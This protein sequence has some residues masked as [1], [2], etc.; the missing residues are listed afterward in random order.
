M[1]Q[2]RIRDPVP[3]LPLDPGS[4]M[5]K[6]SNVDSVRLNPNVDPDSEKILITVTVRVS[7]EACF[8]IILL[9]ICR[10]YYLLSGI[11]DHYRCCFAG[12]V[13]F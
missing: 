12:N 6:K 7:Q 5:G 10:I 11:L 9:V 13:A 8:R 1:L 4:G 3:F 2:I